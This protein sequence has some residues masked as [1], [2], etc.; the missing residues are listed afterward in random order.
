MSNIE[1]IELPPDPERVIVGLRDTGYEFDTAV[2]DIVDNSIA[3]N[4]THV[5]LWLAAD[6]R[7]N[8]RLMIADNGDG[9]NRDGLINAM[10]YGSKARPSAASL[11]KY[12]LGLKTASTAFCKKLSVISRPDG[13]T[14]ALMA[15][16]DLYHVA[17]VNKWALLLNEECDPEAL[18]SLD[19][20]APG[21]AGTVVLWEDVDRLIKDYQDKTGSHARKALKTKEDALREH[22]SMIYQRFLD[23][24]DDRAKNVTMDLN[25][26]PVV[27][28]D[29]FQSKYS[30]LVAD[31]TVETMLPD[32]RT[33]SFTA[34]AYI[35]PRREEF[36][37]D[38]A[39]SG[40]KISPDR[41]GIYVYREN[42]LIH[43]ADWLG[44]YQKETHH[45]GLRVEFS[46]DHRLDDAFHLDIKKSQIILND[47]LA[48]WLQSEFLT[49]PRRE[50]NNRSR[51]GQQKLLSKKG[52]GAHDT[53]NNNI[54]NR[55]AAAGGPKVSIANPNTGET[56]VENKHGTTRL[57]LTIT[58]AKR[59][60]E[61]FVQPVDGINNGLLFKPVLIEGH[62]G[63]QLNT[64]HPYYQKVYIP[65]LNRSVTMQGLDSLMW[66]L[67]VAELSTVQE[68]TASM[69]G[70]MRFEV[71]RILEKLVETLPEPDVD[72]DV[73]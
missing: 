32:E 57:K 8:I 41:Q 42:R 47:D 23:S 45:T 10:Q 61:V 22:L 7:G 31:E 1:E 21:H 20:V 37:N 39:A 38:E 15:T 51:E 11:G 68:H 48:S 33:A 5:Q 6:L 65:N 58:S 17:K 13:N 69:F 16:W 19:A 44:L 50:A 67:A 24:D 34:R 63:I 30:E 35:L 43:D 18:E 2:A 52:E 9:M 12:G 49:A 53:S 40:A 59:P 64:S 4:A 54:R 26:K 3:A 62:K 73:A 56:V 36:P 72:K 46:F 28:W 71:S 60:G 14:P 29:P 70:D 55:E 25:G 27:A 66:A